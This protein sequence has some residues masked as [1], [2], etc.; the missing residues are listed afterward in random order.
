[1]S[2]QQVERGV[3]VT[4]TFAVDQPIFSFSAVALGLVEKLAEVLARCLSISR[5]MGATD[6]DVQASPARLA[7]IVAPPREERVQ[8][9]E[10]DAHGQLRSLKSVRSEGADVFMESLEVHNAF[11]ENPVD[12]RACAAQQLGGSLRDRHR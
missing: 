11:L 3:D 4:K 12:E 10:L 6:D 7:K 8:L 5:L 9:L 2:R 1:V